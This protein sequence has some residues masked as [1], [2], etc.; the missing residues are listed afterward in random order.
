M[1]KKRKAKKA[2]L[3]PSKYGT[4]SRPSARKPPEPEPEPEPRREPE[5]EPQPQPEPEPQPR[6]EPEP[7]P[8]RPEP[9]PE[10]EPQPEPE[11]EPERPRPRA[12]RPPPAGA[13]PAFGDAR[14]VQLGAD[15]EDYVLDAIGGAS[16]LPLQLDRPAQLE[17]AREQLSC[18]SRRR[19][20]S[21]Y[22]ARSAR[23]P[24]RGWRLTPALRGTQ[25][26]CAST[27]SG[28]RRWRR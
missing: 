3:D 8:E 20:Q 21:V 2:A 4:T 7:Q 24:A 27:A 28:T 5:P 25:R 17:T 11:P 19:L 1:G 23:S 26:A 6:R 15:N 14:A 12:R 13:H 10:P 22:G 9:H 18:W 16:Q